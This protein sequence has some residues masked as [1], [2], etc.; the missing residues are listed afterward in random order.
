[1]K[2]RRSD[3]T[4]LFNEDLIPEN[5]IVDMN[6]GTNYQ[7]FAAFD[8][9]KNAYNEENQAAAFR[10]APLEDVRNDDDGSAEIA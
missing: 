4:P 1:M 7:F 8:V 9:E 10:N 5:A 2:T 3:V 6:I